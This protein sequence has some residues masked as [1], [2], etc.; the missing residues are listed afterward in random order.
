MHGSNGGNM[1]NSPTTA[2]TLNDKYGVGQSHIGANNSINASYDR[3]GP[4]T[5]SSGG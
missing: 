1:N 2:P 5:G 3:N 4:T